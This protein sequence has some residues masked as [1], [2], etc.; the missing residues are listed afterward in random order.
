MFTR[1]MAHT[2]RVTAHTSTEV[3]HIMTHIYSLRVYRV[4]DSCI[5]SR[6]TLQQ[7]SFIQWLIKRVRDDSC[8]EFVSHIQ[9]H[10]T[11]INGSHT[12][13]DS[14]TEFVCHQTEVT[15]IQSS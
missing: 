14:D 12:C 10:G 11:H 8:V 9:S 2:Y 3:T 5:E 15:H 6:H 4:R 7:K 13:N 1:D